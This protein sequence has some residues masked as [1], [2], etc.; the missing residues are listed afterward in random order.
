LLSRRH[1]AHPIQD[2]IDHGDV[3]LRATHNDTKISN[4]LF[5]QQRAEAL[6]VIDLDTLMPG[7]LLHDFGDLVRTTLSP[8]AEDQSSQADPTHQLR[9]FEALA[10]GF[11]SKTNS[12][13][14]P[15][16]TAL[17]AESAAVITYELAIRF[18]TDFLE[19][20]RYFATSKPDHNL[21]RCRSQLQLLES[22]ERLL[23]AMKSVIQTKSLQ[24]NPI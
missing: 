12:L 3:P 5:H 6:C 16:E 8:S 24:N 2:A 4:V 21:L 23:P 11:L 18:L 1:L 20:D 19:G 15:Q 14:T 13:L 10:D 9:C 22:I 7:S 17:L